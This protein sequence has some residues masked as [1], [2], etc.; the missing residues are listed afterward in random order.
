MWTTKTLSQS[1]QLST[2]HLHPLPLQAR[3]NLTW[4]GT[5]GSRC[6][7][8]MYGLA[9]TNVHKVF[10]ELLYTVNSSTKRMINKDAPKWKLHS[11]LVK[12]VQ[13]EAHAVVQQMEKLFL[14]EC[15]PA[16]KQVQAII[17]SN[18]VQIT[19]GWTKLSRLA[20]E[21]VRRVNAAI[22][23]LRMRVYNSRRVRSSAERS[24]SGGVKVHVS[25]LFGVNLS[26][27]LDNIEDLSVSNSRKLLIRPLSAGDIARTVHAL[28]SKRVVGLSAIP[29]LIGVDT[30]AWNQ[31]DWNGLRRQLLL[32]TPVMIVGATLMSSWIMTDF[33]LQ[34]GSTAA[35]DPLSDFWVCILESTAKSEAFKQLV[36]QK[37]ERIEDR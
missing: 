36:A 26:D 23:S 13:S 8:L 31:H 25:T 16:D 21:A 4:K 29:D 22:P 2:L 27:V 12:I 14:P 10:E 33:K 17:A 37:R 24:E 19:H 35:V 28:L 20:A 1:R 11:D 15:M 6:Q 5:D 32:Y 34:C 7:K 9:V 3:S 30:S 18:Q